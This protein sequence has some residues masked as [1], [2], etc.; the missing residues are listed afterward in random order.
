[1]GQSKLAQI[2]HTCELQQRYGQQDINAYSV[3]PGLIYPEITRLHSSKIF[4]LIYRLM[5]YIVEKSIYQGIQTSLY[6]SLSD[7]AKPEKFHADCKEAKPSALAY[8]KKLAEECWQYSE[9]IIDEK[10]K[11]N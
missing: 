9:R 3:H 7:Q 11:Y 5:L 10:M 2:W 1:Y 8:N 6:C 4:T